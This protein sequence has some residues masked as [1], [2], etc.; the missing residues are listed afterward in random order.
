MQTR[1]ARF[2]RTPPRAAAQGS[3]RTGVLAS[4]LAEAVFVAVVAAAAALRDGD[5]WRVIRVP[6]SFVSGP[7]AVEPSGFVAGDVA[8]GTTLH[9]GMAV[10]V[11]WIYAALLPRLG[12]QPITGGL[13]T[14]AVLYA[15]GF[16]ILPLAFPDRLAAFWL[17]PPGRAL[18]AGAHAIYGMA[19]G[20][21]FR[22]LGRS[23]SDLEGP[24]PSSRRDRSIR[25]SRTR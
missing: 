11:G 12:L 13:I 18:Q 17:P 8:V 19:F 21:G 2:A 22:L 24:S 25:R 1:L 6:G 3:Y 20:V 16:W 14:G 15:L 23:G 4:L 10:L 9:L 7:D 5:P